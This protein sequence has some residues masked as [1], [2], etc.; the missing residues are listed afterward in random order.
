MLR[1]LA[2]EIREGRRTAV[3][4]VRET[5]QRI[6]AT[7]HLNAIVSIRAEAALAEARVTDEAIRRGSPVGPLAGIPFLVKDIED[8]EGLP[9]TFGSRMYASA[10]PASKDGLIV[11]RLRSLGAIAVGKTNT[12]ELAI[13]GYT[14][15][16]LFGPTLNPWAPDWSPGGSSGGSAAALAAGIAPIATASDVGGSVRIPASLCGLVG[17]KPTLGVIGRDPSLAASELNSHGLLGTTVADVRYQLRAL[18]GFTIGDPG[19][20][21]QHRFQRRSRWRI[22]CSETLSAELALSKEVSTL[23]REVVGL[24]ERTIAPVEWIS[25]QRI[26]KE[27]RRDDLMMIL[28]A[29]MAGEL[30]RKAIEAGADLLDPKTRRFLRAGLQRPL[31]DYLAARRRRLGYVRDLDM[32]L[33]DQ[34]LLL[35]PTLT[36]SGWDPEGRMPDASLPGIPSSAY[37]TGLPNLTG[38]PALS[39]PGGQH[40]NGLPFGFQVIGPRFRDDLVLEFGSAWARSQPWSVAAPGYHPFGSGPARRNSG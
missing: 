26:V 13:E 2:R 14:A 17:L 19:T 8:V 9:T 11:G 18:A 15:N 27:Y 1:R 30:G 36:V 33:A 10:S 16:G 38:H 20:S 5:V 31:E 25:P 29:E 21:L 22:F 6:S 24:V 23:F 39:V 7:H 3:E 40:A 32:L 34:G 4:T 35:T 28:G 37:N 12:P